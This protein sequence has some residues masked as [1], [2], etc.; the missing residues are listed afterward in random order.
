MKKHTRLVY[1]SHAAYAFTADQL[2]RLAHKS[3][4][5]NAERGVTGML[6]YSAGHFMQCLEGDDSVVALTYK[7]VASDSRH[8][9]VTTLALEAAEKRLFA[10]WSMGLLNLDAAG[11]AELDRARLLHAVHKARRAKGAAAADAVALL[12]D[13]RQQLPAGGT[14]QAA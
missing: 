11:V 8:T 3:V 6:L 4:A 7:R 13:F 10:Q 2:T 12:K 1:V 9:A 14:P 5:R